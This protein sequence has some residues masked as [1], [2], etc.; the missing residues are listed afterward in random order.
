[1]DGV[2]Y[3]LSIL[4]KEGYATMG[5]W[6]PTDPADKNDAAK[7]LD[8]LE[9]TLDDEISHHVRVYELEDIKKRTDEMI[10]ALVDHIC[11]L[12]HH[13]LI[14]YGSDAAIEFEVQHRLINAIQDEDI[15]L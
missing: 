15:E 6:M 2:D 8:Y 10:D 7:F 11:Q 1:M 4:R 5:H 12:A 14:G 13:A 3:L 9:S